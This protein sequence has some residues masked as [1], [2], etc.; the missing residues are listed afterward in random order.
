MISQW[1][2]KL[3]KMLM[4]NIKEIKITKQSYENLKSYH[5]TRL[6]TNQ[7]Y[8][9]PRC[10]SKASTNFVDSINDWL[11]RREQNVCNF[12]RSVSKVIVRYANF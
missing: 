12:Q 10:N 8:E 7:R 5:Q 2:S 9:K 3:Q 6:L 1:R 11:L 4:K